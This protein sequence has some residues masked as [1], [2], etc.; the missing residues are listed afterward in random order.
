MEQNLVAPFKFRPSTYEYKVVALR[1]TPTPEQM[2][3]ADRPELVYAYWRSSVVSHPFFN[4][5]V[6]CLVAIM[7]NTRRRIKGHYL[8][9]TGTADTV[10]AHPRE[11]FRIAIITSAAAIVLAHNHPSGE[12]HPSEADIKVT[13]DC[14]RA[15]QLLKTQVLDHVIIG[16]PNCVS[17][18]ELGYFAL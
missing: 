7:L 1:E 18:K 13:R 4:P 15:G 6:E 11:I 14:I 17:L 2:T 8:I 16:N 5:E 9:A 12:P 3:L 10:L